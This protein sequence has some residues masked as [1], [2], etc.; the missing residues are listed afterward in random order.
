[1]NYIIVKA[2]NS[3]KNYIVA[4]MPCSVPFT[5][6]DVDRFN[7]LIHDAGFMLGMGTIVDYQIKL[8]AEENLKEEG[9]DLCRV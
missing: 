9:F 4:K 6:I 5:M 8:V 1:M 7:K 2:F 3:P